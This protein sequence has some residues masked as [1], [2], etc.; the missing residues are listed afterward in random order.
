MGSR[1]H[2]KWHRHLLPGHE[3]R[4]IAQHSAKSATRGEGGR[5]AAT[6][7][8]EAGRFA[9]G[10]KR[11]RVEGGRRKESSSTRLPPPVSRLPSFPPQAACGRPPHRAPPYH[12]ITATAANNHPSPT[13]G[14]DCTI[15][16]K[17]NTHRSAIVIR[18]ARVLT[19]P[20]GRA[21]DVA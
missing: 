9:Q 5:G 19:V 6:A 21:S 20:E 2:D 18:A 16:G 13:A 17:R 14:P 4:V 12:P 11:R 10:G 8:S 15:L 7:W 1:E 3:E